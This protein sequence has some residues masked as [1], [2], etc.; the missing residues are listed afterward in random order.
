MESLKSLK[1]RAQDLEGMINHCIEDMKLRKRS[2][3]NYEAQIRE[4]Y[5]KL[6][7]AENDYSWDER[8]LEDYREELK[9]IKQ[10]IANIP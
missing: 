8:W 5:K 1:E 4:L 10:N 7:S 3:Q 2:A 9:K 6:A